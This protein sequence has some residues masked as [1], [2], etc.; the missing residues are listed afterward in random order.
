MAVWSPDSKRLATQQQDEREVG[1]MYLVTT[2]VGPPFSDRVAGHPVLRS[3]P[4]PL[5][6]DSI[7]T[8][9]YRVVVDADNGTVLRLRMPADFHRGT[10]EDN[11]E[12]NDT[13]WSPD[14]ARLAIA[15]MSRDNKHVWLSV[16][17]TTTGDVRKVFDET[18]KT[19][20]KAPTGWQVLWPTNEV[21]W[22]SERSNWGTLYLYDL[23][24]GAVKNQITN[25][26]GPVTQIIRVDPAGRVLWFAA[27][28]KEKGQDPY[29]SH[30]YR[31][32]LDGTHQVSLTPDDGTHSAQLSADGRWLVDTY[33]KPD[34]P[35]VVT[36]RDGVTGRL[37]MPLERAD[38]SKLLAA[39]W[40]PPIPVRMTAHDGKTDIYGMMFVPTH[41]DSTQEVSD[42]QQHLSRSAK[43]ERRQPRIHR[44]SRRSTGARRTRLRGGDD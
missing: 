35:P 44:R 8:M 33:S 21:I 40:K 32:N 25:G 34:V 4:F 16:A 27:N 6:G 30:V 22:Y 38:I 29:F 39:G 12:L 15:S 11:I 23:N 31:V 10:R 42:R 2:P 19:Q 20:Y 43:R 14:G 1:R 26:D 41:L 24:T 17:N 3:V 13:K 28:G 7:V 9:M 36:L 37:V 5:P 18:Q